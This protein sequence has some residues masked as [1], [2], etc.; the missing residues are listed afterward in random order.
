MRSKVVVEVVEC[1]KWFQVDVGT[2]S[3]RVHGRVIYS[4][5][6]HALPNIKTE[7]RG[8]WNCAGGIPILISW[9][10][11]SA[12][13]V[14]TLQRGRS[15]VGAAHGARGREVVNEGETRRS[16]DSGF[17]K[18]TLRYLWNSKNHRKKPKRGWV[19]TCV[20]GIPPGRMPNVGHAHSSRA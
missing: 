9:L 14:D 15:G 7:K 8:V 10:W 4:Q 1:D 5:L 12:L 2:R 11:I 17:L 13:F 20:L 16:Q 19:M 3:T 6:V 18:V